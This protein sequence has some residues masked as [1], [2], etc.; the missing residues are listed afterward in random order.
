[1]NKI[2]RFFEKTFKF[3][4]SLKL[5]IVVM[6]ALAI[7]SAIG[8][9]IEARYDA[10]YAQQVVYHS[11]YMYITLALLCVNLFNVM[12]DRWPW[13]PHHAGFVFAHI[14]II[15]LVLGSLVTRLYGVDGSMSFEIGQNNRYVMMPETEVVIFATFG[16]GAYR[17]LHGGKVDFFKKH[18]KGN[19]YEIDLGGKVLKI[20]DYYH[21]AHREQRVVATTSPSGGPAVRVQLQNSNV[22]LAQ[23]IMKPAGV[24]Q[25]QFELGPAKI[26]LADSKSPFSY[27]GGNVI[28]LRAMDKKNVRY[29]IFTESKKGKTQSGV[30]QLAEP[31][32][33]GW[34]GL[35]LR[36]LKYIPSAEYKTEYV[37]KDRPS[38]TTVPAALIEFDG[39]EQ[40][41][42]L[43]SNIKLFSDSL[44]YLVSYRNRL[45]D[46]G[47]DIGLKNFNV[48]RYQ[49]TSRAMSYESTVEVPGLGEILI[50][51][52]EPLK[53]NGF[54]FYQASFQED[55]M[56]QAT[57]SILSV[58][59]DPGRWIKYLGSLLIVLG[60]IV[61][62][63]FK[64]YRLKIMEKLMGSGG[65][66]GSVS[67]Q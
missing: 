57:T 62:F 60:S 27:E 50:S 26:I 37:Q 6:S 48:G 65:A 63:Y 45:I 8:T 10:V 43:N 64:H 58:N 9:I 24:P 28:L 19:N 20:K 47:F 11:P 42:G 35:E 59:K 15:T 23:W 51:M 22:N 4:A 31:V 38:G 53:H 5:A 33:T 44:M 67:A 21:W 49:G 25:E 36:L 12:L 54:T 52:N 61:M 34:M 1:M 32:Q 2:S 7:I 55:E 46:V 29:E 30:L 41:V 17:P 14:G 40:W 18:P 3:L 39:N 16:D 13:K 66:K 56:G